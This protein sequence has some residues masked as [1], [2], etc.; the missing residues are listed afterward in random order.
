[1]NIE[2][3]MNPEKHGFEQCDNCNGY[4]SSLKESSPKCSKCGGSGLVKKK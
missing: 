4:G 1:M 2:I 3:M